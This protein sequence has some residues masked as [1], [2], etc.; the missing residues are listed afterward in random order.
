VPESLT[1]FHVLTSFHIGGGERVAVDLAKRQHAQ[2]HRVTVVSLEAPPDG[3]LSGELTRAGI[4]VRR[5]IKKPHGLDPTLSFRLGALFARKRADVVHTHNPMPLIYAALPGRIVRARVIH[6]KHGANAA[7]SRSMALR[8]RAASF[9]HH[10]V[11]VSDETA[12]E[13]LRQRDSA[14]RRIS[15]VRNGIDLSRFGPD[16]DM[17]TEVRDELGI[18]GDAWVVGSV[19]RLIELKNHAL[20]IRAATPLLGDGFHLVIVGDGPTMETLQ[21]LRAESPHPES[22]HLLGVRRDV[23]R[24]LTGLD[25]FAMSSQS[26]GLP[27]VVP[28]AMATGLPIVCTA[29]GGLPA[30]V[31][32][33]E[34]GHL[35]PAGD[36]GLLRT[37]LA[38]LAGDVGR[39][40][41][42]GNRARE[43]ALQRYSAERMVADYAALYARD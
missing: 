4:P 34:T 37:R 5:V 43:V 22:I 14:A 2:G 26:E 31:D 19:G 40:R 32:E 23:P 28:E 24:L 38:Q 10:F 29:V 15:V 39:S 36:E 25:V 12:E 11:P 7:S 21:Q 13:A 18:P 17:R 20:L 1:I 35:V 27:L 8:R 3:P 6:T 16:A 30:V 33:D 9:V 42:L 41:T